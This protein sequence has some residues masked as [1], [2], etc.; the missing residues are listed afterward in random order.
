MSPERC[1]SLKVTMPNQTVRRVA[2]AAVS[3]SIMAIVLA[4]GLRL[5]SSGQPFDSARWK[6]SV[7][8][9]DE[10]LTDLRRSRLRSDSTANDLHELLG[11]PDRDLPQTEV[12]GSQRHDGRF[13]YYRLSRWNQSLIPTFSMLFWMSIK[14]TGDV[15]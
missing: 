11:P 14:S 1:A 3:A 15:L 7:E 10:M 6:S 9:R 4:C 2:V 13:L 5:T 8:G 12:S